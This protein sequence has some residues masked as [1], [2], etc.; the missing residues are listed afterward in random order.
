MNENE[1]KLAEF[2]LEEI[3]KYSNVDEL[4]GY[5]TSY[6]ILMEAV[7]IRQNIEEYNFKNKNI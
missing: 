1:Q 3:Y 4:L 5:I 6:K 7:D 2:L